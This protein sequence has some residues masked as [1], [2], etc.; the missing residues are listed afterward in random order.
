MSTLTEVM[1]YNQQFVETE[2][3]EEFRTTKFLIKALLY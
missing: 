3:Y 2:K 1:A